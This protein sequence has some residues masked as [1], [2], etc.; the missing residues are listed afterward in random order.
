MPRIAIALSCVAWCALMTAGCG[1]SG[2][3]NSIVVD[4]LTAEIQRVSAADTLLN[5]T[6]GAAN[7]L[8][9]QTTTVTGTTG[10]STKGLDLRAITPGT[11]Y[12]VD[13]ATLTDVGGNILYPNSTGQFHVSSTGAVVSS[14]P[15][16]SNQM[17]TSTV[18]IAFDAGPVRYV[19]PTSGVIATIASGTLVHDLNSN[20][21]YAGSADNWTLDLDG[22]TTIP[23]ATPF[24]I[25]ASSP[26]GVPV[27]VTVWG[28]R[29]VRTVV[30]R[31][32]TSPTINHRQVDIIISG[33]A[34]G[35]DAASP[36]QGYAHWH[37]T[38]DGHDVVLDRFAQ[39]SW[40]WDFAPTVPAFSLSSFVDRMYLVR[41]GAAI[42]GSPFTLATFAARFRVRSTAM[43]Q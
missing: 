3:S 20:Y 6:V 29:Q 40:R 43:S 15:L 14:W 5:Q 21:S 10:A 26:G 33:D 4:P 30:T 39:L 23:L 36:A 13:F 22:I 9:L 28:M 12:L 1:S 7:E 41:D 31:V 27:A 24:A 35:I 19:D 17:G 8:L 18:T 32:S 42:A 16:A 11:A 38:I 34:L 25:S 37:H 2:G